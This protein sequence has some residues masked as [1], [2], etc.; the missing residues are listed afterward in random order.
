MGHHA[1]TPAHTGHVHL[2]H[3][4][5]LEYGAHIVGIDPGAGHQA[6]AARQ[7]LLHRLQGLQTRQGSRG[8]ARA[9][10]P[11]TAGRH[12]GLQI[13]TPVGAEIDGAMEGDPQGAGRLD[14]LLQ[15]GGWHSAPLVQQTHHHPLQARRAR[16]SD[17]QQHEF[18]LGGAEAEIPGTGADHGVNRHAG[19]AG[20]KLHETIGGGETTQPQRRAELDAIRAGPLCGEQGFQVV[21]ADFKTGHDDSLSGEIR[22][23]A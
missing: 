5:E 23:S 6:G 1:A 18:E 2:A 13:G 8:M 21:D 16:R 15:L 19:M 22:P 11:L 12:Y 7:G 17:I 9:Q 4:G 20:S 14:Q 3:P 10:D